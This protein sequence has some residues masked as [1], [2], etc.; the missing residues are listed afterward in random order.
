MS[1]LPPETQL[2]VTAQEGRLWQ[3][4]GWSTRWATRR[5]EAGSEVEEVDP[6]R[7]HPRSATRNGGRHNNHDA[8]DVGSELGAAAARH[9]K[10]RKAVEAGQEESV[11]FSYEGGVRGMTKVV[12]PPE[13]GIMSRD[14]EEDWARSAAPNLPLPYS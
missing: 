14:S 12:W 1:G 8:W 10:G 7:S 13:M 11:K 4:T 9:L 6:S 2:R 5:P 3:R